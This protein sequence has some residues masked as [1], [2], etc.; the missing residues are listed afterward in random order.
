MGYKGHADNPH[1]DS[2][3]TF[4]ALPLTLQ[5]SKSQGQK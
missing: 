5:H 3:Q 4:I 2:K 1:N